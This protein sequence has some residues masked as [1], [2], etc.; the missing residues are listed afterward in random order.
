MPEF[1][2]HLRGLTIYIR[3][4]TNKKVFEIPTVLKDV[5]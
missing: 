2:R 3:E 5:L 4:E 1:G